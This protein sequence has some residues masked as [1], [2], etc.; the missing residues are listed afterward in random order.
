MVQKIL[1]YIVFAVGFGFLPYLLDF[2]EMTRHQTASDSE[3]QDPPI[4]RSMEPIQ[5]KKITYQ[6]AGRK[7]VRI[8]ADP[9]GHF[10]TTFKANNRKIEGMIDTGATYVVINQSTARSLG[11]NVTP[12]D[13]IHTART[14]NGDTK[15]AFTHIKRMQVG[16][17][18]ISDVETFIL[19]DKSLSSNL[20]G[21][22]F[23]SQLSSFRFENSE[24]ILTR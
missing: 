13:F 3:H 10:R 9:S 22:S 2:D 19:D 23:M 12:S 14:A 4:A 1:P 7:E 20:I 5:T 16:A 17:I 6:P 11:I 15:A 21:M 24:L 8:K 18:S